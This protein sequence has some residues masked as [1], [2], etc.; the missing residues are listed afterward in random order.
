MKKLKMKSDFEKFEEIK[1]HLHIVINILQTPFNIVV[2]CFAKAKVEE[3]KRYVQEIS[4]L[5]DTF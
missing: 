4:E 2:P 1:Q 5:L 3:I